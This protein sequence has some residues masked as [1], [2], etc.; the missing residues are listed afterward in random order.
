[1]S[2]DIT[3]HTIALI[4]HPYKKERVNSLLVRHFQ[5]IESINVEDLWYHGN[6]KYLSVPS[7]SLGSK[8]YNTSNPRNPTSSPVLQPWMVSPIN[9]GW[10]EARTQHQSFFPH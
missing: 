1:M 2:I 9:L 4:G 3:I 8:T 7:D 10:P 5:S 6:Q